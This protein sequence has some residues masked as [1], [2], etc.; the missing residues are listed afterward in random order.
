M[1]NQREITGD[2]V[3]FH[4]ERR[5]LFQ[6]CDA[7]KIV[8]YPRYM[9][10][11]DDVVEDWLREIGVWGY[12]LANGDSDCNRP[13]LTKAE[14]DFQHPSQLGDNLQFALTLQKVDEYRIWL[15]ASV[16][17]HDE[18]RLK[19]KLELASAARGEQIGRSALPHAMYQSLVA[20][21]AATKP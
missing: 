5:V 17:C 7:A 1:C 19:V 14:I 18:S 21:F 6:D 20:Q 10:M 3:N 15:L 13:Q 2:A 16:S 11:L 12:P 4:C 8:F 9:E